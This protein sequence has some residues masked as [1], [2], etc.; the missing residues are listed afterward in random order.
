LLQNQI[1]TDTIVVHSDDPKDRLDKLLSQRYPHYSRTYFQTLI[2]KGA[3]LINKEKIKKRMVPRVGDEIQIYFELPEKIQLEPENIPLDILFEDDHIVVVNKPAGMVVHP[4]AGNYQHTF[5]HA[6]LYHCKDLCNMDDPIRP[7]IVHRL[8]KDTSGVLIAAK[9]T[10]AH[11]NLIQTFS[12][13]KNLTKLYLAITCGKAKKQTISHAIGR[14][15]VKRK[16]MTVLQKGGKEAITHINPLAHSLTHSFV[17]ARPITGRTHQ[18][19][20]HLKSVN[21]PILGDK[22]YGAT[23]QNSKIPRQLLHAY[24]LCL[25]HPIYK[26][27]LEFLAPIPQDFK[28]VLSTFSES[29]ETI[30]EPVTSPA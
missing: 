13:K 26:T 18:I 2:E 22:V 17:L 10:T 30:L 12:S 9:T 6:L 28:E 14:H 23:K 11:Q 19:R 25:P 20:V 7:G 8:D 3:V 24:K 5:V 15:P 1:E 16:E 27:P 4:G 29:L 21:N